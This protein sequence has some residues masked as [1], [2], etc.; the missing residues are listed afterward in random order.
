MKKQ[1]NLE[2]KDVKIGN[3]LDRLLY[4]YCHFNDKD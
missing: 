4:Y 2:E 1:V 3:K